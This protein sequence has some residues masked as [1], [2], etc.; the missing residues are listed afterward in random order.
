MLLVGYWV[1]A[2]YF[3]KRF[4]TFPYLFINAI[5][6]AGKTKLLDVLTLLAYNAVFSPNMSTST[7][8]RLTQSAGAT[9]LLDETENL[10]DPEKK[11]EFK[12]LLLSGYKRGS[13]CYRSEKENEKYV[14]VP[15][16]V[17]SP[18]AIANI[19]GISDVLEDR[20]IPITMKRGRNLAIINKDVPSED[21]IWEK[22]RDNLSRLY[23]KNSLQSKLLTIKWK[24]LIIYLKILV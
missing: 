15:F 21:P 17:Y 7:L 9:T 2:T 5:K 8:F 22:I 18:K 1:I 14:P 16:E 3:H 19:N 10:E 13:F 23:F 11:A 12:S 20:C 4:S 6:R 24:L